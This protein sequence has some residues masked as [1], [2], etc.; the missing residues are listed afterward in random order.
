MDNFLDVDLD[1]YVF[2]KSLQIFQQINN[3]E[4]NHRDIIIEKFPLSGI[5]NTIFKVEIRYKQQIQKEDESDI[6]EDF[7]KEIPIN[8]IFFKVFGRISALVDRRLETFLMTRLSDN[9]LGPRIYD[10]DSKT[11]RVEEFF[12]GFYTLNVDNMFEPKVITK[13]MANFSRLNILGG[14]IHYYANIIGAKTKTEFFKFLKNEDKKTNIV[15]FLLK[16][17]PLAMQSFSN[18]KERYENDPCRNDGQSKLLEKIDHVEYTLNNLEK[19]LFDVFPDKGLFVIGHN[20]SHPLNI[21]VNSDFSNVVLCDYEY[22]AYNFL[23]FDIVNY[24]IETCYF[25]SHEKFPFY[26][27]Y[28]EKL[29]NLENDKGYKYFLDFFDMFEKENSKMFETHPIYN[30]LIEVCKTKDYYYRLMGI[31]SVLWFTFAVLY[32]DYDS[33]K[34]QTGYDYL[35]FS[36]DRLLIYDK[37][38]KR[39]IVSKI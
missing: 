27:F 8:H 16:M 5:S 35:C 12:E 23:G 39:K 6:L 20:D 21:L 38:V 13:M 15:N 36:V 31:S 34:N 22:S 3:T 30:D 11:Y 10:T 14:E 29:E 28:E 9:G 19:I 18:F 7:P 17:K 25:M 4:F 37:I 32:F 33:V 24:I 1:S 26:Q 2:T